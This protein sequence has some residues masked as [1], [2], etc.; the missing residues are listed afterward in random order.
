MKK[1][2]KITLVLIYIS[3]ISCSTDKDE[4]IIGQNNLSIEEEN[5]LKF[6]REEEKLARD[7]YLFSYEKYGDVIFNNIAQSEQQHMDQILILL[8]KYQITDSASSDK[9]LFT[10][11]ELQV[12]YDQLTSKASISLNEALEV[13]A[14][15]EDLDIFDLNELE[16][17]TI[18]PDLLSVYEKLEC[19]SRNH[20]RS[21]ISRLEANN[22]QYNPEYISLSAFN[23]IINGTKEQCGR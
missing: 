21:F 15:I 11:Q 1:I 23:E 17:R 5:D 8:N 3:I 22:V 4:P 7:V 10:D 16:S 20:L 2:A 6:S 14:I 12:L 19:G 18:K 9:G 13:G